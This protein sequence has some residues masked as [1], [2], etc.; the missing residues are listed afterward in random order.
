MAP[1]ALACSSAAMLSVVVPD[2]D[3]I[4]TTESR[5]EVDRSRRDSSAGISSK[6][7]K[8]DRVRS[9]RAAGCIRM[10]APPEP[11][12][13]RFSAP[14]ARRFPIVE[15]SRSAWA[16]AP[17]WMRRNRASSRFSMGAPSARRRGGPDGRVDRPVVGECVDGRR[18][19]RRRRTLKAMSLPRWWSCA[20]RTGVPDRDTQVSSIS[21]QARDHP[22]VPRLDLGVELGR[23][24]P[25]GR[26]LDHVPVQGE[27][28]GQRTG[29]VPVPHR[30]RRHWC[31][32]VSTL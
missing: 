21:S 17:D 2:S 9:S 28:R 29:P 23:R 30:A 16:T 3:G 10:P 15:W 22:V 1:A 5:T 11:A 25:G 8:V 26:H 31:G 18:A 24:Q 32:T 20:N 14:S 19:Q 7:G 12:K 27:R 6:T 13:K 4:T